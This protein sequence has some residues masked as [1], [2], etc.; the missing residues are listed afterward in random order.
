MDLLADDDGG[1]TIHIG[2]E[3][4]AGRE[5]NWI[6]TVPG[7]AWFPYF[8]LYSPTRSF[9]DKTWVLPDIERAD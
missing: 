8:R 1:V 9:L 3:A 6:P 4:P 5:Q 2:P 7:K